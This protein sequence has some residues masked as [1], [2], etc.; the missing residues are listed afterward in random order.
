MPLSLS[1][2]RDRSRERERL[3][4]RSPP[5]YDERPLSLLS[6]PPLSLSLLSLPRS[7]DLCVGQDGRV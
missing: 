7:L 5:P 6:L 4:Y 1:L 2:S 3:R